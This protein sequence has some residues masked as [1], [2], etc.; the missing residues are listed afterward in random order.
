VTTDEITRSLDVL[1]NIADI[2]KYLVS[3]IRKVSVFLPLNLPLYSFVIFAAVPSYQAGEVV[4][5]PPE[6]MRP[7]FSDLYEKLD[8]KAFF[9]RVSLYEGRREAY[10]ET[11][12]K[13]SQVVVFTGKYQNFAKIREACSKQTLLI[14]NGVGHNPLVITETADLDLAVEK[15]IHVKLFNNGQDCAGPDAILVHSQII[16]EF[17][18]RL[19]AKL[20]EVKVANNYE[21]PK[22]RVGPLFEQSS[23]ATFG[24][25]LGTVIENGGLVT[26][27]GSVDYKTNVISPTIVRCKVTEYANFEEIYSPLFILTEYANNDELMLYFDEPDQRYTQKQMYVSVFGDSKNLSKKIPGSILISDMTVHDVERGNDEYGGYSVGASAVS[28]KGMLLCKPILI[29]R[30]IFFFFHSDYA[31]ALAA[32]PRTPNPERDIVEHL[33]RIKV[34]EIF[35]SNLVFAYIFGSYARNR[36]KNYS[37]VDTL[38]CVNK[39][40]TAQSRKFIE[41]MFEVSEVFGKVPDFL[42]PAE[43]VTLSDIKKAVDGFSDLTLNATMNSSTAYDSMIWL[44]SLSHYKMAVVGEKNIPAGWEKVFPANSTRLL[45]SFLADFRATFGKKGSIERYYKQNEV[46]HDPE[47]LS[48]FISSLGNGRKLIKALKYIPFE[49]MPPF[50]SEVEDILKKRN[51]FGKRFIKDSFMRISK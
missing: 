34:E 31:K 21:D 5:R 14:Y 6:K 10:L 4:V 25:I 15:T 33:F 28:Y 26:Y 12:C 44:H 42:Y 20:S 8:L 49:T 7:V 2:Q 13:L 30:E 45:K 24:S 3:K 16:D 40:V 17:Q 22:T 9:P 43:M 36:E 19:I 48:A 41:L 39:K 38:V 47:E 35:G 32:L 11:H 46:P 1:E 27:G 50:K 29:P 51:S 37:D 18:R 23:L